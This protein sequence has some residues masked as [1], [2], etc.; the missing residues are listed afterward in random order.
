MEETFVLPT[1]PIEASIKSPKVLIIYSKPKTGKTTLLSALNNCLILDTEHGSDYVSALKVKIETAQDLKRCGDAI[2]KAGKPYKYVAIDTVTALEDIALS[3]ALAKYKDTPIGKNF[4]SRP[5]EDSVLKL[6]NGAGYYWLRIAMESLTNYIETLAPYT[7]ICAH[8]KEKLLTIDSKEV[9]AADLDL[10]GKVKNI[11]CA[12]A[13]AIGL[14]RREGNKTI[15]SFK[16]N[17]IVTCGARPGH[18]R[19]QEFVMLQSND[20]NQIEEIG[21]NKIYID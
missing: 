11:I 10:T 3:V 1:A 8:L 17:D 19:N 4:G 2:L 7:I 5:G 9:S 13:D 18:L 20:K 21:W 12:N 15:L 14:L 16:T 6:P